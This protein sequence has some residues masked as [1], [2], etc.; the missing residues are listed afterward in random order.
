ML[1]K[2]GGGGT[3]RNKCT[4]KLNCEYGELRACPRELNHL[5]PQESPRTA[6]QWQSCQGRWP[7]W[8]CGS[9]H[10]PECVL[11]C[12]CSSP[13]AGPQAGKEALTFPSQA[14]GKHV[15]LHWLSGSFFRGSSFLL[16]CWE[17]WHPAFSHCLGDQLLKQCTCATLKVGPCIGQFIY[18][19]N[20]YI[21]IHIL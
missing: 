9:G 18:F 11:Q 12:L 10:T 1:L 15:P 5:Q 4:V 16:V 3:E 19:I 7:V 6:W 13:T 8:Q 17:C 20:I 2:R 14:V 21:Y